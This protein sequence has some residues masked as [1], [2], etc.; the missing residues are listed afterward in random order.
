MIEVPYDENVE[1]GQVLNNIYWGTQLCIGKEHVTTREKALARLI[2]YMEISFPPI[3][4]IM[5]L[6]WKNDLFRIL[7]GVLE[8]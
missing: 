3:T 4:H 2:P 7:G 8:K 5:E 6:G 1:I